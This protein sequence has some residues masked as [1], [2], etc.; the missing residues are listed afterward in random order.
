MH[1]HVYISNNVLQLSYLSKFVCALLLSSID[2]GYLFPDV[3][4]IF[5]VSSVVL[6]WILFLP[7]YILNHFQGW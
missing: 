2:V 7:F 3:Q 1:K 4:R 5:A 6:H